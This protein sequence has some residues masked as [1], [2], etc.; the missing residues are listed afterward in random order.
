MTD[1]NINGL[2]GPLATP[3]ADD[4]VPVWDTSAAQ[5]LKIRRDVFVGATITG[6]GTIALGGYT[7]T[8][9]ATGTAALVASGTWTPSL[10]FGGADTALTYTARYGQYYTFGSLVVA[11]VQIELSNKGSSTGAA[12]IIGLPFPSINTANFYVPVYLQAFA[13]TGGFIEGNITPNTSII[14]LYSLAAGTRAALTN[15]DFVN[16]STFQIVALYQKA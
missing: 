4:L 16:T 12:T 8:V 10:R 14:N 7:L 3:A 6:G 13:V 11:F 1:V 9:P 2:G 15:T 5:T